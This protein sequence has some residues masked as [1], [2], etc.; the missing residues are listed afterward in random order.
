VVVVGSRYADDLGNNRKLLLLRYQ[1]DGSLDTTFGTGEA[2]TWDSGFQEAG[3]SVA[4]QADRKILVTGSK[5]T[6]YNSDRALDRFFDF[7]HERGANPSSERTPDEKGFV[8]GRDL[9]AFGHRCLSKAP[10]SG[11]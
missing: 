3:S 11:G 7:Y 9:F 2:V 1:L 5:L 10:F 4:L 6:H 8:Q